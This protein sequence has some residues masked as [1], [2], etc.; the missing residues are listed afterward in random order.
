M[1]R[2]LRRRAVAIAAL[3]VA[4][5][6]IGATVAYAYWSST[7]QGTGSA[8]GGGLQPVTV[9]AFVSGDTPNSVLLPGGSA[10]VILRIDNPN[11][12]AV[13]LV[14]V[15]GNGT[16]TPDAGHP[17][18]TVMGVTFTNQ[19]GLSSNIPASDTTLVHL[20]AAASMDATSSN[21]CQGATFT[22]PVSITVHS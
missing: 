16:I 21:G 12:F 8:A 9:T 4:V 5:L 10:D 13:T 17:S 15:S 3:A 20:P 6:G 19:T 22:V 11:P 2:L 1:R 7:G 14:S 18:C